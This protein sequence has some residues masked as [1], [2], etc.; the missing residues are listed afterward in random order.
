MEVVMPL[1]VG[2]LG[3]SPICVLYKMNACFLLRNFITRA[4]IAAEIIENNN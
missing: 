3:L 1:P 2:G 4:L